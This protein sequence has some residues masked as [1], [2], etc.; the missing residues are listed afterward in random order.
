MQFMLETEDG[1]QSLVAGVS[2]STLTLVLSSL[3]LWSEQ[4]VES[5]VWSSVSHFNTNKY[6]LRLIH[7]RNMI[8]FIT[9]HCIFVLFE[10]YVQI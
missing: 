2:S 1:R 10:I 6:N 5:L 4:M 3:W 9:I 7:K 8:Y